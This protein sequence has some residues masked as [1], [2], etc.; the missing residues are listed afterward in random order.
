MLPWRANTAVPMNMIAGPEMTT[1]KTTAPMS[2]V[3]VH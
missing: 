2:Q 1:Q 3:A